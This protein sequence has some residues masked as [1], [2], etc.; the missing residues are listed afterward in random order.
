MDYEAIYSGENSFRRILITA[1]ND[2]EARLFFNYFITHNN[3]IIPDNSITCEKMR[4]T[5]KYINYYSENY[6][7]RQLELFKQWGFMED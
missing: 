5:K 3:Y 1:K 4:K 7:F 2:N 6:Y